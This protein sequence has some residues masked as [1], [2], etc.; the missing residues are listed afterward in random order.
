M[1][2]L[3]WEE[4]GLA[5]LQPSARRIGKPLCVGGFSHPVVKPGVNINQ[6]FPVL[7]V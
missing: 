6:I 2:V 3:N 4:I 7:P 5:R 1:K